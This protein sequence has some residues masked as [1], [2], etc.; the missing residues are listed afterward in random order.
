METRTDSDRGNA[1]FPARSAAHDLADAPQPSPVDAFM[2]RAGS[3]MAPAMFE[4]IS[5][6]SLLA[7]EECSDDRDDS[8]K[9][10]ATTGV[11]ALASEFSVAGKTVV[12]GMIGMQPALA[13]TTG[14]DYITVDDA[15]DIEHFVVQSIAPRV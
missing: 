2:G 11:Q 12:Q 13:V 6:D 4:E 3:Q 10:A 5:F 14:A 1:D 9:C 7:C 15:D 8:D